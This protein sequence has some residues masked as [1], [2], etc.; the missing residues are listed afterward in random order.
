MD[1]FDTIQQIAREREFQQEKDLIKAYTE[2]GEME[3]KSVT[4]TLNDIR[5][6]MAAV[7]RCKTEVIV[8]NAATAAAIKRQ[9]GDLPGVRMI[10]SAT[11]D[12]GTVYK[13]VDEKLKN[14]LLKVLK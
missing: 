5:A 4:R 3:A 13:V 1:I 11:V 6:A 2:A 14:Q 12:T 10:I 7:T 9:L 8:L